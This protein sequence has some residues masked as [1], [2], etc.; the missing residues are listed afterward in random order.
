[1][2]LLWAESAETD[3]F[4]LAEQQD[5]IAGGRGDALLDSVIDAP[6]AL[7]DHPF[8]GPVVGTRGWRKWPVPRSP[9]ILLYLVENDAIRV[10]RVVD[11]RSDWFAF[12]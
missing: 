7:C 8:L 4:R 1:M 9:L 6:L 10:V 12:L 11:A 3:L 2:R 5:R